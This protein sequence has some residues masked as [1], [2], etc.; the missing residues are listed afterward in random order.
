MH[1]IALTLA[2]VSVFIGH[3][4]GL[5]L[6]AAGSVVLWIFGNHPAVVQQREIPIM[7]AS[8]A[9]AVVAIFVTRW[10]GCAVWVLGHLALCVAVLFGLL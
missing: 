9:V 8:F 1:L 10:K 4:K 3:W 2:L 7:I 6:Y 5:G